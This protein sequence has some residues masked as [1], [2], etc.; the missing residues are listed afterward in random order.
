MNINLK[1]I[2]NMN[3]VV[4]DTFFRFP[5][6]YI[7]IVTGLFFSILLTHKIYL[8]GE[9]SYIKKLISISVLSII[10]LTSIKLFIESLKKTLFINILLS[11]VMV[12]LISYSVWNFNTSYIFLYLAILLSVTFSA[13]IYKTNEREEFIN[14]NFETF[15]AV[16]FSLISCTILY[17]GLSA[18]YASIGYLFEFKIP[19]K[20]YIDTCIVVYLGL[21]SILTLSK[22]SFDLSFSIEDKTFNKAIVFLVNY[23][24][25]PLLY[26][27]LIILYAYFIKMI[28]QQELPK[29][30][31][32]WMVLSFSS[33]GIFVYIISY[34]I[35]SYTNSLVET[36]REY[37]YLSLVIPIC[38]LFIAIYVRVDAYGITEA[39]YAVIL[40]AV[41]LS[42]VTFMSIVKKDLNFKWFPIILT[43]LFL[44]ASLSPFNASAVSANSQLSRFF[45]VLEENK[46]FID[47]K[48]IARKHT[49][50]R[51]VELE[52]NS[53]VYYLSKNEFALEKLE[54]YIVGISKNKSFD[55]YKI[56]DIILKYLNVKYTTKYQKFDPLI[57]VVD[58][59]NALINI[60]NS[61]YVSYISIVHRANKNYVLQN[62][63]KESLAV[64]FKDDILTFEYKDEK[65]S[66][67]IKTHFEGLIKKGIKE[68]SFKTIDEFT[69]KGEFE[70]PNLEFVFKI[71]DISL[72]NHRDLSLYSISG[73]LFLN[74]K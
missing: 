58:M 42:V 28:F 14:F 25:V 9:E 65:K 43:I 54:K 64:S 40:L 5:L 63:E 1:A 56:R 44:F 72:K 16:I 57:D 50:S 24:F 11:F 20:L 60:D 17:I 41:W 27:Y 59:K 38:V 62:K 68:L 12:S 71:S 34:K 29:G 8:F 36:F 10:C 39:R 7:F 31:L 66:F 73:Y 21:F 23:I 45:T 32:S 55:A 48:I 46:L 35:K 70:K 4:K 53:I 51:D 61:K 26:I 69:I 3:K 22:L 18:I 33:V 15:F 2:F 52:I 13:L 67:N 6:V 19:S 74:K 49:L 30:N 47:D 37:F